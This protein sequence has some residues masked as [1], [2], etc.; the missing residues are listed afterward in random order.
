MDPAT[1]APHPL[2]QQLH[3]D[4][5]ELSTTWCLHARKAGQ[6]NVHSSSARTLTSN[7][8][9]PAWLTTVIPGSSVT[10]ERA[11]YLARMGAVS[12]GLATLWPKHSRVH[13]VA[14][15]PAPRREQAPAAGTPRTGG[16]PW[17]L[18]S[19]SS[20]PLPCV[21]QPATTSTATPPV[22]GIQP[23]P[24]PFPRASRLA[25]LRPALPPLQPGCWASEHR[26]AAPALAAA[27]YPAA[28]PAQLSTI[29]DFTLVSI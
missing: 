12:S 7:A 22:R 8:G 14:G 16:A 10:R 27:P 17:H 28:P 2:A 11:A 13:V 19:V 21:D 9:G 6:A 23:P 15:A 1:W 25:V 20:T 26:A 24:S 18:P 5:V 3:T 4:C 29:A